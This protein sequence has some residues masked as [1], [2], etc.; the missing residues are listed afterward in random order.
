MPPGAMI[1]NRLPDLMT[2]ASAMLRVTDGCPCD[3]RRCLRSRFTRGAGERSSG[4]PWLAAGC[5]MVWPVMRSFQS[6]GNYPR[7]SRRTRRKADLSPRPPSLKGRG[8]IAAH[9]FTNP[10][11]NKAP[12]SCAFCPHR[13]RA[14]DEAPR[15]A[16]PRRLRPGHRRL[17]H[18]EL[19]QALVVK[20][21]QALDLAELRVG[22][23]V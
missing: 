22:E 21:D 16:R 13:R 14:G 4:P 23:G 2:T 10:T 6:R 15:S 7:S 12:F 1:R 8:S 18:I 17:V 5:G 20:A 11:I 3:S 19:V 9:G